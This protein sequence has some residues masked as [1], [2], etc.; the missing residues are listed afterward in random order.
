M[1]TLLPMHTPNQS[2][3]WHHV[4]LFVHYLMTCS[5]ILLNG[6]CYALVANTKT[7]SM[8]HSIRSVH[9]YATQVELEVKLTNSRKPMTKQ[10]WDAMQWC[11]TTFLVQT[12]PTVRYI[13]T[14]STWALIWS[15][16]RHCR[17]G[18]F[19]Y[20]IVRWFLLRSLNAENRM[21]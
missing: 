19:Y 8:W 6:L 14:W 21:K 7:S 2:T 17:L 1:C 10:T 16:H 11:P 3:Q 12:Y 20:E 5:W 15:K 13:L 9:S 4:K 18:T